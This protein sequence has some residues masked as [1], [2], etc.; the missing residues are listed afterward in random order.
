MLVEF[1]YVS[2]LR[3]LIIASKQIK[4]FSNHP[5]MKYMRRKQSPKRIIGS[6]EKNGIIII[7]SAYYLKFRLKAD[8][9][10]IA[11]VQ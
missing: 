3:A 2:L 10:F 6:A 5:Y 7:T 11:K 8:W 4:A 9:V 1:F